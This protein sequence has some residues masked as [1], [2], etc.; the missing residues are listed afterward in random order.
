MKLTATEINGGA[1]VHLKILLSTSVSLLVLK[2]TLKSGLYLH[3]KQVM[4]INT[5]RDKIN[6]CNT[7][8][9]LIEHLEGEHTVS[10]LM[11]LLWTRVRKLW[12]PL[13]LCCTSAQA[14]QW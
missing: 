9:I 12:L 8:K 6:S 4:N 13:Q 7:V 5:R 3:F 14:H 11:R 10:I 2:S 1:L